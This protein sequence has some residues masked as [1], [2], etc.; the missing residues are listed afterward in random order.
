MVGLERLRYIDR[1]IMSEGSE[2]PVSQGL[3]DSQKQAI[4]GLIFAE[5]FRY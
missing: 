2:I 3:T 1:S 5:A 4:I